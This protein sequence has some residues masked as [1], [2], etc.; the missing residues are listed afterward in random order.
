MLWLSL[1]FSPQLVS[2]CLWGAMAC[3]SYC[4][5]GRSNGWGSVKGHGEMEAWGSGYLLLIAPPLYVVDLFQQ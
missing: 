3:F 5:H 1:A 4:G 2:A